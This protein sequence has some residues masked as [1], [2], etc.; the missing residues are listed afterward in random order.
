MVTRE[1]FKN[2]TYYPYTMTINIG[3]RAEDGIVLAADSMLVFREED[4]KTETK[5]GVKIRTGQNY[6]LTITGDHDK[7]VEAFLGYLNGRRSLEDLLNFLSAGTGRVTIP[8]EFLPPEVH[9]NDLIQR[10]KEIHGGN[11]TDLSGIEQA[12]VDS[13]G[14]PAASPIDKMMV[15][16][17]TRNYMYEGPLDYAVKTGYFREFG[18]LNRCALL[19][20]RHADVNNEMLLAVNKPELGLYHVDSFGNIFGVKNPEGVEYV[21]LGRGAYLAQK[22]IGS[23]E[24]EDDPFV[25][26]HRELDRTTLPFAIKLAIGALRRAYRELNTG[27][28]PN[29]V[30]LTEN[31]IDPQGD[32][33]KKSLETAQSEAFAAI[34]KK[35]EQPPQR[36][37]PY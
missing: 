18:F 27:G 25:G 34:I 16:W 5:S 35:Y 28:H 13:R 29:I 9:S 23:L 30:V 7:Y 3:I 32:F 19:R 14:K 20:G 15:T 6:A 31:A 33:I 4:G 10:A 24:Y 37:L 22:Y 17:F 8:E 12:L 21:A 1:R 26:E 36:K 2:Y 11:A